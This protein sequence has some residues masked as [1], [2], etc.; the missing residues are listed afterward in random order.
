M[1]KVR[2][3]LAL[4][5]ALLGSAVLFAPPA[6]AA[7]V[8]TTLRSGIAGLPVA[9]RHPDDLS[10]L[11]SGSQSGRSRR[12]ARSARRPDGSRRCR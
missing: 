11:V 7:T 6:Q 9:H 4:L 12:R 2:A 3:L 5:A 1:S 10:T 8:S